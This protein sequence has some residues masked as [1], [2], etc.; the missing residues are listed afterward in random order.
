MLSTAERDAI[1][2]L[3]NSYYIGLFTAVSNWR[4]P[5]VTECSYSGYV[6]AQI[7]EA[8][9]GNTTPA[10]GRQTSNN[11]VLTFGQ[12]A[13]AGTVS[14]LAWGAFAASSGGSPVFIAPIDATVPLVATCTNAS[15]G[16]LQCGAVHGWS[17]DQRVFLLAAPGMPLP[18]GISE[19]TE[20]FVGTV[21]TTSSLTLSTTA[22][23]ANPV[24]TSSIGS[25]LIIPVTPVAVVQNA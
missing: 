16:V 8:A 1:L 24:N 6:R 21:P 19:N 3:F 15:P 13:D 20:Y 14:P 2:A 9:V 17:A 18:T 5:T 7:T 12:K 25:A 11:G 10:G 22:A 4:T 23:N